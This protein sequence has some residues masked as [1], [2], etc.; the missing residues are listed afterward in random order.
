MIAVLQCFVKFLSRPVTAVLK[1]S[2]KQKENT[3][4]RT[5]THGF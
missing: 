4:T 1:F 2:H 5:H 3:H